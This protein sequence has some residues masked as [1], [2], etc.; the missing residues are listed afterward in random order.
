MI[1]WSQADA[2]QFIEILERAI[3]AAQYL[4]A[5]DPEDRYLEGR[6]RLLRHY[7]PYIWGGPPVE[8]Q[9][10]L[11]EGLLVGLARMRGRDV[12]IVELFNMFVVV[13]HDSAIGISLAGRLREA[14][15]TIDDQLILDPPGVGISPLD[16]L[17]FHMKHKWRQ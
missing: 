6:V 17:T 15:F 14:Q 1:H 8:G 11:G 13:A 12:E 7:H 3:I 10:G 5:P 2:K 4:M 16:W 9:H